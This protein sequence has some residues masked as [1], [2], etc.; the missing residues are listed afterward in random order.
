MSKCLFPT[1]DRKAES[2]SYCIFHDCY[3]SSVAAKKK[4]EVKKESESMKEIKKELKKEYPVFLAK[5]PLCEAKFSKQCQ[6]KATVVH[7]LK[8][9]APAVVLDQKFWLPCCP[10]CNGE[11]EAR[12][13]DAEQLGLK[14]KRHVKA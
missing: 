7:H 5:R 2:N 13:G 1:C 11:I 3:S 14:L 8:G 6:K 12:H 10:I 4:T 9:R